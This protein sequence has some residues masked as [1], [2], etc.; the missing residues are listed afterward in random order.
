MKIYHQSIIGVLSKKYRVCSLE[1]YKKQQEIELNSSMMTALA[2]EDYDYMSVMSPEHCYDNYYIIVPE[3]EDPFPIAKEV[4]TLRGL[5]KIYFDNM[6]MFTKEDFYQVIEKDSA[7]Q[8]LDPTSLYTQFDKYV[9][10]IMV[11]DRL[12]QGEIRADEPCPCKSGKTYS[13][14]HAP[15]P[16]GIPISKQS[17]TIKEENK[18]GA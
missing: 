15:R 7:E 16:K 12:S 18:K 8:S 6:G 9:A 1:E 13:V 17:E 4:H 14:C 11:D 2:I 5:A 3:N 10:E